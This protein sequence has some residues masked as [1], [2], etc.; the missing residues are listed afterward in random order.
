MS[1]FTDLI[2]QQTIL[3]DFSRAKMVRP[4]DELDPILVDPNESDESLQNLAITYSCIPEI[5]RKNVQLIEVPPIPDGCQT[6]CARGYHPYDPKPP[7]PWKPDSTW[8][9]LANKTN[10][11]CKKGFEM[12]IFY[13]KGHFVIGL[14]DGTYFQKCGDPIAGATMVIRVLNPNHPYITS[15]YGLIHRVWIRRFRDGDVPPPK[16]R[17]LESSYLYGPSEGAIHHFSK[18][19]VIRTLANDPWEPHY[20]AAKKRQQELLQQSLQLP[21]PQIRSAL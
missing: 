21:P 9:E 2:N 1:F 14:G 11:V 20:E 3:L 19:E 15:T 13:K 16:K 18:K 17:C 5:F 12:V 7:D 6:F 4:P 10:L 8:T